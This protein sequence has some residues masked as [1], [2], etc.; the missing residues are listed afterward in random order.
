M[1]YNIVYILLHVCVCHLYNEKRD[2]SWTPYSLHFTEHSNPPNAIW[3]TEWAVLSHDQVFQSRIHCT[4]KA[5]NHLVVFFLTCELASF[6]GVSQSK[7]RRE[8][9]HLP[10]VT[11]HTSISLLSAKKCPSNWLSSLRRG[12]ICLVLPVLLFGNCHSI[13]LWLCK[14]IPLF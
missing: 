14:S 11:L 2:N 7:T 12:S 10:A 8:S 1:Y 3:F 13:H 5:T 6:C 9:R 4:N